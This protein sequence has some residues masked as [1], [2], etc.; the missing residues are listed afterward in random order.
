LI[1]L[2]R[3]PRHCATL[4]VGIDGAGGAGK[5]TLAATLTEKTVATD[6]F[7]AA[8]WEWYD[9]DRLRREVLEPLQRDEPA[10]YRR[11]DWEDGELK[12][13]HD[14]EPGG[15]VV[16]EGVAALDSSLRAAYDYRIWVETPQEICFERGLERDGADALPLWDA[17]SKKEHRYWADQRPRDSADAIVD[18]S[19]R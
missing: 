17:W 14:V 5:S 6:D 10:R 18:G 7:I 8:P 15:V 3:V 12:E 16:V 1:D 2:S 4:L 19:G 9:F 11:M 13:W